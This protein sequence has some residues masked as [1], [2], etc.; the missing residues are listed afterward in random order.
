[1][2]GLVSSF[3]DSNN[4]PKMDLSIL[5]LNSAGTTQQNLLVH[6]KV[7]TFLIFPD[8]LMKALNYWKLGQTVSNGEVEV[9]MA[10][11]MVANRLHH[12]NEFPNAAKNSHIHYKFYYKSHKEA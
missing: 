8:G 2:P 5:P 10:N 6:A 12:L 7:T 11:P 1:M 3:N 9:F 4:S